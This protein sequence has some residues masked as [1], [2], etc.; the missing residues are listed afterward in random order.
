MS[1]G[2][3]RA[4]AIIAQLLSVLPLAM[5]CEGAGYGG[6][7]WW[8][9]LLL[10][11]AFAAFYGSGRLA[12]AWVLGK[13]HK[14][15][16]RALVA[17]SSK[18]AI[19]L[20]IAA[21]IAVCAAADF[22]TALY[23]YALP[24]AVI[25]YYGGYISYGKEYSDIFTRGWFALYFVLAII[26]AVIVGLTKNAELTAAADFQL[27]AGFGVLIVLSAILTN[28]TN[29]DIC[30]HQRDAGRSVL[31]RGLRRYNCLLSAAVAAAVCALLLL[32]VPLGQ[33]FGSALRLLITLIVWLLQELGGGSEA[34]DAA[35]SGTDSTEISMDITDNSIAGALSVLMFVGITV[36]LFAL[37][38]HIAE[39]IRQIFAPLFRNK[40]T[41]ELSAYTDELSEA[42]R[43]GGIPRRKRAQQLYRL[44]RKETDPAA[45]YRL[46]Y[47][48]ML[49]RLSLTQY[50]P[51]PADNTYIHREKG[52]IGLQT[53]KMQRIVEIYNR[54]RYGGQIPTEE[55]IRFEEA[56]IEEIRR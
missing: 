11:A 25:M 45:K 43:G 26:A 54:L 20:P 12:A 3:L 39:L 27:C 4:L 22:S 5:L 1:R 35:L 30:T 28:Q 7:T 10:Y 15:E 53:D 46:G 50:P 23:L 56:F 17:F 42:A 40:V 37:R 51:C 8:H 38:K 52:E 32:A 55:E 2:F 18:L 48:F 36:L 44:Y 29:I 49:L 31:P 21:F 19:A 16:Y 41:E 34:T 33:L 14:R 24:A 13:S 9:F 6:F 47:Q